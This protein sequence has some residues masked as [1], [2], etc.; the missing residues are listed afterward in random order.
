MKEFQLRK[1]AEELGSFDDLDKIREKA[2]VH[3][4]SDFDEDGYWIR[5]DSTDFFEKMKY[6]FDAFWIRTGGS[7]INDQYII[8]KSAGCDEE[9]AR[10]GSEFMGGE[11]T[12]PFITAGLF[13][14]I[15]KFGYGKKVIGSGFGNIIGKLRGGATEEAAEAVY[16]ISKLNNTENFKNGA[17]EH[18]LEGELL[19]VRL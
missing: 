5:D 18:I 3:E 10:I 19:E 6:F 16:D 15:T 13:P 12:Q 8:F 7:M 2:L 9:T 11:F 1:A 17:L 14:I 4:M